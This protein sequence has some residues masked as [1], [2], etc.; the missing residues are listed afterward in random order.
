MNNV[1]QLHNQ[2]QQADLCKLSPF[3]QK[4][5]KM[6]PSYPSRCGMRYVKKTMIFDDISVHIRANKNTEYQSRVID[7]FDVFTKFLTNSKFTKV[8]LHEEFL[9][10]P[11]SFKI[12]SEQLTEDGMQWMKNNYDK[13]L[14][15]IDRKKSFPTKNELVSMLQ[16]MK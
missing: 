3:L 10:N 2:C 13:W 7:R 11:K 4:A 16:N 12:Q 9:S 1:Q 5:A 15:K 6:P 8:N 14:R